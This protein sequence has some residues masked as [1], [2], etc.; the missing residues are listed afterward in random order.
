MYFL[1]VYNKLPNKS[2]LHSVEIVF[3]KYSTIID[4]NKTICRKIILFSLT[5]TLVTWVNFDENMSGTKSSVPTDT[6]LDL[7]EVC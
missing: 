1:C 5:F 3:V 4:E 6:C 2:C 7:G